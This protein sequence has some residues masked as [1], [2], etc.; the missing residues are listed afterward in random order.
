MIGLNLCFVIKLIGNMT[1]RKTRPENKQL[2]P[3]M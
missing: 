2:I 3:W 1:K